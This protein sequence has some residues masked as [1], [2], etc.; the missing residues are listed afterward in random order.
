MPAW[1][2]T[3]SLNLARSM[4]RRIRTERTSAASNTQAGS[5]GSNP[6]RLDIRNGI[7][8]LPRRQREVIVLHYYLDLGVDQIARRLGVSAGTVK[9]SLHR[10]RTALANQLQLQE[11]DRG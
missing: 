6:D 4:L 11:A 5:E 3:V 8:Q 10:G 9:T 7:R 1:V 2:T